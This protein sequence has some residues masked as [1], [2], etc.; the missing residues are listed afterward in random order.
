[1]ATEHFINFHSDDWS[2]LY[3][4]TTDTF[5][6][7]NNLATFSHSHQHYEIIQLLEGAVD[8]IIE[9]RIFNMQTGDILLIGARSFH[10]RKLNS[11]VYKRRVLEFESTFLQISDAML[12]KLLLPYDQNNNEFNFIPSQIV[13]KNNIDLC[14]DKIEDTINDVNKSNDFIPI[15]I[16]S[17]LV[18]FNSILNSAQKNNQTNNYTLQIINDIIRYIDDNIS[19]KI[20]LD[21]LE[22]FVHL[23]KYYISHLFK[24]VMGISVVNY[25]IERKIRYAEQLI[26]QGTRPTQASIMVGY[27]NYANFYENYKKL[28]KTNPKNTTTIINVK[29]E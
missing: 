14:F 18:E 11:T 8:F 29:I 3:H 15:H 6:S 13:K 4:N 28:T 21:N 19:Q 16:L 9:G 25:I 1:M 17:L 22:S 20:T 27:Y 10:T 24:N 5:D 7:F 23:S 26:R 2:F 12:R